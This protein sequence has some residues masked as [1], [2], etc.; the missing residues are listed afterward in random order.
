M[1]SEKKS[2]G[3]RLPGFYNLTL[4]ERWNVLK[5]AS[6]LCQDD[7]D[8][9]MGS[10]GSEMSEEDMEQMEVDLEKLQQMYQE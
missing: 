8:K 4:E 7:L 1:N 10:F 6:S 3:S 2:P 5:Q 9:M